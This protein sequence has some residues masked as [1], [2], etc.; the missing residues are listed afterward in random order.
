MLKKV[1]LI[2]ILVLANAAFATM[3]FPMSFDKQIDEAT[4]A[5]EVKLLSSRVF[6]NSAGAIMTEY[7]F[8][9]LESYNLFQNDLDQS[10]LKLVMPG[11]TFDG[12]TSMVD[13]APV[14]LNG[15][16]TFLLLKKIESRLYLSNFT[17][18][19]YKIQSYEGKDFY[20]SEVFPMDQNIGRISKEKMIGLIK[21]KW[22]LS[23]APRLETGKPVLSRIPPLH[24]R[25]PVFEKRGPAQESVAAEEV[26]VF[27]W[28]A[29][30]LVT[31]F[32]GLIFFKLGQNG[33]LHKSE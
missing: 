31:F 30:I 32:F 22:K 17:L 5:A 1:W 29:L 12:V 28:S 25:F 26:P 3:F 19:K 15:E 11:G 21:D 14:F 24:E 27:F 6:K 20:V 9:I 2:L 8:E 7:S 13:G 33:Q 18:G 23:S 16:K 4:S 10:L